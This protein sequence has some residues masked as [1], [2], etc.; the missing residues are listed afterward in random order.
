[1]FGKASNLSI[2][3]TTSSS[4]T[5]IG[6]PSGPFASPETNFPPNS[7]IDHKASLARPF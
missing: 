5:I 3:P 2:S 7:P 4:F 1:M 6:Y